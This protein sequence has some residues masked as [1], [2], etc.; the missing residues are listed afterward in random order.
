MTRSAVDRALF[1]AFGVAMLAV[2]WI[3]PPLLG[4]F[5]VSV[6]ADPLSL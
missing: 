5:W 1:A 4:S 6:I 2:P 3:V